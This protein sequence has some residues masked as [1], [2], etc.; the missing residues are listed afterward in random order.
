MSHRDGETVPLEKTTPNRAF[1]FP[2]SSVPSARLCLPLDILSEGLYL[3]TALQL[4][5]LIN[6]TGFENDLEEENGN[7]L[8]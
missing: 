5:W 6:S 4:F 7:T 8:F 1:P 2:P 3:Q